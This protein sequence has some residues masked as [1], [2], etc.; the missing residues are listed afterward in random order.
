MF[1]FPCVRHFIL[2]TFLFF[3]SFLFISLRYVRESTFG[4]WNEI[5]KKKSSVLLKTFLSRN[6]FQTSPFV[7]LLVSWSIHY[8]FFNTFFF[9]FH[10]HCF[11]LLL[12]CRLYFR[13]IHLFRNSEM[14]SFKRFYAFGYSSFYAVFFLTMWSHLHIPTPNSVNLLIMNGITIFLDQQVKCLSGGNLRGLASG[15]SSREVLIF[16]R[17]QWI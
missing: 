4:V 9:F 15:Q 14:F 5:I 3:F 1:V 17:F 7:C 16:I 13:N 10:W 2:T 11:F 6:V 8:T 12:S